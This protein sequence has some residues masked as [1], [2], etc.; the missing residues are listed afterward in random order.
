MKELCSRAYERELRQEMGKLAQ[1]FVQWQENKI[2][3]WDLETAIHRFHNGTAKKLYQSYNT[4]TPDMLLPYAL[5]NKIIAYEEL[6]EAAADDIKAIA[7]LLY[8]DEGCSQEDLDE[9]E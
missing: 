6:P 1:Q 4:L 3:V 7:R 8:E 9:T 5:F 2:D